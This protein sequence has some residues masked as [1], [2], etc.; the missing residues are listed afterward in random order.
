MKFK[1]LNAHENNDTIL[2]SGCYVPETDDEKEVLE[3][4]RVALLELNKNVNGE[5]MCDRYVS[6]D[7]TTLFKS[8]PIDTLYA[9]LKLQNDAFQLN[10]HVIFGK[11]MRSNH[12]TGRINEYF[13]IHKL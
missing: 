12:L 6:N 8:V 4:I 9:V 13:L 1:V 10:M 5:V 3:E 7:K 2:I 11:N